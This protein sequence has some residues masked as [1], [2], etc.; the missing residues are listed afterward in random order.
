MQNQEWIIVPIVYLIL[1]GAIITFIV[2]CS[3]GED[4]G[5]TTEYEEYCTPDYMGGCYWSFL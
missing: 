2:Q 5:S 1:F 3:R 4:I